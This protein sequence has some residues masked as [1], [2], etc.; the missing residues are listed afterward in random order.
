MA[1]Q[2]GAGLSVAVSISLVT[3]RS[4]TRTCVTPEGYIR[5]VLMRQT[6]VSK[7]SFVPLLAHSNNR[8]K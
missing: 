7:K 1:G 2:C 8:W 4:T 3:G 5:S 6:M